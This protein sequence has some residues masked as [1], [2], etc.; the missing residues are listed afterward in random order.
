MRGT[1]TTQGPSGRC[2]VAALD[3]LALACIAR[4]LLLDGA[5]KFPL[6]VRASSV[7]AAFFRRGRG[8]APSPPSARSRSAVWEVPRAPVRAQHS[9]CLRGF[10]V[11][12][13][14]RQFELV[15]CAV[16]GMLA[17]EESR[18]HKVW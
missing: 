11:R 12:E 17:A 4:F 10:C 16:V 13:K 6:S 2:I 15:H 3:P 18:L 14:G 1:D 8:Q 9:R 7:I 5:L